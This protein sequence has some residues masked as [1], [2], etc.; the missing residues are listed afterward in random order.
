MR[1]TPAAKAAGVSAVEWVER[2]DT[3]QARP[4]HITNYHR[5]NIAGYTRHFTDNNSVVLMGIAYAPPI[6]RAQNA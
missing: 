2:S 6:Y 4:L 1:A 3:H 5:A